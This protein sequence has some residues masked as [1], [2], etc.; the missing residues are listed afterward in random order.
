MHTHTNIVKT[1]A[2][3]TAVLLVAAVIEARAVVAAL[4]VVKVLL[5][6]TSKNKT[7]RASLQRNAIIL[8]REDMYLFVFCGAI[9]S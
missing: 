5:F 4:V 7:S 6:F 9:F 2:V 8:M 3:A 1:T